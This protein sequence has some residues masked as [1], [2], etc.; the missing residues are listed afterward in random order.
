M[1]GVKNAGEVAQRSDTHREDQLYNRGWTVGRKTKCI[2]LK[3]LEMT[4]NH[5]N[6][7]DNQTR[8]GNTILQKGQG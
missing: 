5:P 8:V 2:E 1:L 3:E 6:N 4:P 7:P